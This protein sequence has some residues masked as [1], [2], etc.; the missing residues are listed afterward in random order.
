M[1]H[2]I[3]V[4]VLLSATSILSAQ[5]NDDLFFRNVQ[6]LFKHAKGQTFRKGMGYPSE[7]LKDQKFSYDLVS[8]EKTPAGDNT[9][10]VY[11]YTGINWN[12]L[13]KYWAAPRPVGT[14]VGLFIL[15]FDEEFPADCNSKSGDNPEKKYK[16][17]RIELIFLN[18]D[19]GKL[20][21]LFNGRY[22]KQ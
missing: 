21:A 9:T 8:I 11:E 15:E 22:K 19:Y 12:K 18:A 2:I 16:E 10:S 5:S 7:V 17:K 20:M 3:L 6:E 4:L 14:N 1:K 13:K